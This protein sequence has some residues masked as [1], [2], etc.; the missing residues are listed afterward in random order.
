ML[1]IHSFIDRHLGCFH[2][3]AIVNNA[4]TDMGVQ[5]L[6]QDPAFDSFG[7][8][9]ISEIARSYNNSIFNFFQEPP[10]CVLQY[11]NSAQVV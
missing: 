7:Y 6:L 2:I 3:L 1:L 10:Y 4:A 8:I 5:I 9:L 11:A